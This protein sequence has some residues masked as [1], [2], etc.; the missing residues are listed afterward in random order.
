MSW[1]Y[2]DNTDPFSDNFGSFSGWTKVNTSEHVSDAIHT[3]NTYHGEIS[4]SPMDHASGGFHDL[5]NELDRASSYS[6]HDAHGGEQPDGD[7]QLYSCGQ[8]D[9]TLR[10][11]ERRA[12]R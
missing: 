1:D 12:H 2:G 11:A 7:H 8:G 9:A 3:D 6:G 10:A 4:Q 5:S